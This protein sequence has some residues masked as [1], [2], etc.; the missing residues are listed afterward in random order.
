MTALG[1]LS[2]LIA[3]LVLV[4]V[5]PARA[6]QSVPA[7]PATAAADGSLPVWERTLYKTLTYQAVANLSDLALYDVLLGGAAVAGGGFFVANAA[8]AAALYY[9]YEYAWQMFG[10]PPGEK[11]HEDILQ[12]TVLYRVL[13]SSRNFTLGLTFGGST[14]AAI[15]FVGANFV[16]DT[17][18]FVGN[19]YAWDVFRPRAPGQ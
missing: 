17:I 9:G 18:I 7:E 19:E 1:R 4:A 10:P 16:T 2:A 11:T 15:A 8:S 13:N 6:Q 5:A 3:I 14:T 12:K